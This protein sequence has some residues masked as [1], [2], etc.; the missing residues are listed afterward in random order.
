[1]RHIKLRQAMACAT[2]FIT[3]FLQACNGDGSPSS[4]SESLT[5]NPSGNLV[6]LAAEGL[7]SSLNSAQVNTIQVKDSAAQVTLPANALVNLETG[8]AVTGA[9]EVTLSVLAPATNPHGMTAGIYEARNANSG[10]IEQIESFGAISVQLEQNDQRLQLAKGQTATIRIPLSTRSSERPSSIPLYY[11]DDKLA[12]WVQEGSAQLR[13]NAE[14]GYYYEGTVSHFTIW[15]ADRPIEESVAISGC[16]LDPQGQPVPVNQFTV[17][18]NGVDYSGLA[19]ASKQ[20]IGKFRVLAKK[21]G[22]VKLELSTGQGA[23]VSTEAAAYNQ[24]TTLPACLV[25]TEAPQGLTA[26][27]HFEQLFAQLLQGILG[28]PLAPAGSINPNTDMPEM[29]AA[30]TVC[31]SGSVSNLMLNGRAVSG[32]EPLRLGTTESLSMVFNACSPRVLELTT[33][34]SEGDASLL[35]FTGQAQAE[36]LM[37]EFST[38][39][40]SATLRSTL[41]DMVEA[42]TQLVSNGLFVLSTSSQENLTDNTFSSTF[43]GSPTRG[44]SITNRVSQRSA[45]FKSGNL[46]QSNA[47]D[48]TE[49]RFNA[50][51]YSIGAD[52]YILDGAISSSQGIRLTLQKNGAVSAV[53]RGIIGPGIWDVVGQVD[54]I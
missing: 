45:V 47:Q 46:V 42:N 12:L 7:P 21:G 9:V 36:L 48:L 15:N 41:T 2:L 32:G 10:N 17:F 35:Q 43:Q 40:Y 52:E 19:T 23:F 18:S 11:W 51:R 34:A 54:P 20:D 24:D 4:D 3:L 37:Q 22:Q 49:I 30:D 25:L 14:S 16:V 31:Q 38:T 33:L 26:P 28:A 6:T 44:A 13:G 8:Q 53:I 5:D 1:M 39:Q 29:L 50:L 27:A